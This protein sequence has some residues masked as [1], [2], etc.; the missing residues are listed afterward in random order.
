MRVYFEVL[1]GHT[2]IRIFSGKFGGTLGCAGKI[3]LTKEEFQSWTDGRMT[4]EFIEQPAPRAGQEGT[5]R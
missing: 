5:E 4:F 2:H 3:T 1:G